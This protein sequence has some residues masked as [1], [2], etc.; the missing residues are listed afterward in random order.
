MKIKKFIVEGLYDHIDV[1]IEFKNNTAIIIGP[2]GIGKS[3]VTNIFYF[4]ISRQWQRLLELDFQ[5]LCLIHG[6]GKIFINKAE[7][8][9]LGSLYDFMEN[10]GPTRP[11]RLLRKVEEQDSVIDFISMN[12]KNKAELDKY[13]KITDTDREEVL[14]LYKYMN[15]RI[16]DEEFHSVPKTQI[17]KELD[18][19]ISSRVLYLPTYRRIEKDLQEIFPDFDDRYKKS[20]IMGLERGK[21]HRQGDFYTELVSFGMEDVRRSLDSTTQGLRNFALEK[22]NDLSADYLKDVIEGNADKFN[23]NDI[24]GLTEDNINQILNRVSEQALSARLKND[25]RDKIKYIQNAPDKEVQPNDKYLAHYFSKLKSVTELIKEKEKRI[26]S[27]IDICNKYMNENKVIEYDEN[28]SN[29]SIKDKESNNIDLSK[30]SS[31]EKQIVSLFSHLF[32]DQDSEQI[33]IIDEPELSLSVPWQQTFLPDII[34]SGNC[35]C[36]LAVTHSPFIY[37]NELFESTIDLRDVTQVR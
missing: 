23:K 18:E 37:D 31:G 3:T 17:S 12:I 27:F 7:I 35:S 19:L 22:Y 4:F 26:T 29:I 14:H 1:A 8:F 36:L 16:R 13:A 21:L 6:S 20:Q 32:I 34:Q 11:R 33:V 28:K 15:R 10:G 24:R 9:S 25:L 30:L 5:S 2:N